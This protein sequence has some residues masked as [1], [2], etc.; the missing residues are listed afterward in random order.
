MAST[1]PPVI[2]SPRRRLAAR[3]RALRLQQQPD[4]A[5][6]VLN[7]MVEDVVERLAFL[8]HQPRRVLAIG[9]LGALGAAMAGA[10]AFGAAGP[11]ARAW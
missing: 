11:S 3:R 5:R 7:D 8:R 6:Y 2:F 9:D 1:T 4:A 10:V